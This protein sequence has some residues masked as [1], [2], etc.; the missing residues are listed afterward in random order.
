[1]KADRK[2]RALALAGMVFPPVV[3]L[4]AAAEQMAE[5]P[6]V[7]LIRPDDQ[8]SHMVAPGTA[9]VSFRRAIAADRMLRR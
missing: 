6:D 9:G 7:T 8:G 3:P 5:R 4:A 1:M 2:P